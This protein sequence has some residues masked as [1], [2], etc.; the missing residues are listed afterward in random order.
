MSLKAKI[1]NIFI[2]RNTKERI[3]NKIPSYSECDAMTVPTSA[4]KR[5]NFWLKKFLPLL[6]YND[7]TFVHTLY[8]L[9]FLLFFFFCFGL[10]FSGI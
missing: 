1:K 4:M 2:T 3:E 10:Q 5:T 8:H 6:R 9:W 7:Y